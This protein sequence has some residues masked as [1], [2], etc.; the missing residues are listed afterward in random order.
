M[1]MYYVISHDHNLDSTCI[2]DVVEYSF[3]SGD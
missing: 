3:D 1:K 2:Y